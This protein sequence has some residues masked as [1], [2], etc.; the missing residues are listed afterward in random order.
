[1]LNRM[2]ATKFVLFLLLLT[3]SS[4]FAAN[5]IDVEA[6]DY[7]SVALNSDGTVWAW[8][9]GNLGNGTTSSSSIPVQVTGLTD[10]VSVSVSV[11]AGHSLAVKSDGSVWAWGRNDC[12]QLGD[13]TT[14][15]KTTPV[16]VTMLTD[17]VSVACGGLHSLAVKSDGT[18]WAWGY[19]SSGQLGDGTKT[20]RKSPVQVTGLTDIVAVDGDNGHSM[21]LRNDGVVFVWGTILSMDHITTPSAV[22]APGS[23]NVSDS[24][25]AGSGNKLVLSPV[26]VT[27]K[28]PDC[29]YVED[30]NRTSGIKVMPVPVNANPSDIIS[31]I[32]EVGTSDG[33]KTLSLVET[34]DVLGSM[35]IAPLAMNNASLGGGDFCF[36]AAT[37]SGQEGVFGWAWVKGSDGKYVKMWQKSSGLNNI[38]LLVTTWGKVIEIEDAVLPTWFRVSDGSDNS[39]IVT[40][41]SAVS[42]PAIGDFVS[43]T[44]VSSCKPQG[45]DLIRLLKVRQQSDIVM[46]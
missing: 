8:G 27:A 29:I 21:A 31:V 6:G 9:A 11:E 5:I 20:T 13:E 44:G 28:F 42:A 26:V 10:V 25:K 23:K 3:T 45:S 39:V 7:H 38:G 12:G 46:D 17:V 41:P 4:V 16:K 19:N 34:A 43:V 1:M 2:L 33:E 40:I 18:V 15:D 32:A 30:E 24:R 36:N 22:V 14:T 37:G 35:S